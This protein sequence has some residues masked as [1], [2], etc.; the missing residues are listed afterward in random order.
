MASQRGLTKLYELRGQC[1]PLQRR[2]KFIMAQTT[3][4]T[5]TGPLPRFGHRTRPGPADWANFKT[6]IVQ[7]YQEYNWS[8]TDV[9][10]YL[11]HEFNFLAT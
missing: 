10:S 7:L 11:R 1:L 2:C 6:L 9:Q 4:E 5:A 3:S 8:L